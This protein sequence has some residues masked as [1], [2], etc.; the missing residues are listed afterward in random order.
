[1]SD[2]VPASDLPEAPE[3]SLVPATDLPQTAGMPSGTP[4]PYGMEQSDLNSAI[5]GR[6]YEPD[7]STGKE[8]ATALEGGIRGMTGGLSD[9]ALKGARTLAEKYSDDPDFWAPKTQDVAERADTTLG[10][11]ADYSGMGAGILA[12]AGMPGLIAKGAK[13]ATAGLGL[14]LK[15]AS[16]YNKLGATAL[17]MGL[18]SGLFQTSDEVSKAMLGQ[19]GG[20]PEAAVGSALG[21]IGAAGLLGLTLGGASGLPKAGLEAF[22]QSKTA[23][24]ASQ[25][26][27][28]FANRWH[29]N[30]AAGDLP[31]ALTKELEDFHTS[32]KDAADTVYGENGLKAQ[33]INK[34]VP[35]M[36]PGI[37]TQNQEIA[38]TM[39]KSLDKMT[40]NTKTF[41]EQYTENLQN[42]VNKWK[43][44]VT[45]PDSTSADRFNATQEMKQKLQ[46][47]A[48]YEKRITPFS[49]EAG[50]VNE[51]KNLAYDLRNKLEDPEVWGKA[52]EL[53]KGVNSAFSDFNPALKDFEKRFTSK[54]LGENVI[55]PG[56]VNTYA[57]QLGK[58][59]AEIKQDV[60]N[61]FVDAAEK[62]RK[63]IQGLHEKLGVENTVAPA[64][65]TALR[66]T[67]GKGLPNGA[68]AA[69]F[70]YQ[71]GLG[72]IT[73]PLMQ[74]MMGIKLGGT[75]GGPVGSAIGYVGA[76]AIGPTLE[77][78]VGRPLRRGAEASV[79]G[80]LK[81]LGSGETEGLNE[82]LDY[83]QKIDK[84]TKKIADK[85]NGLF[86]TGRQ[87]AISESISEKNRE[88]LRKYIGAGGINQDL[89][90]EQSSQESQPS[91]YALGGEITSPTV[92][93]EKPNPIENHFP[94]QSM[95]LNAAKARISN[96]LTSVKPQDNPMKKPFDPP[97]D[98]R[99]Q[100]RTYNSALDI[101]NHPL[102]ILDQVRDGTLRLPELK[103]FSS[104]YPEL[105]N[106]LNKRITERISNAQLDD[107]KPNYV[108][109]QAMSLFLGAPL[110]STMT[111]ASIMAAQTAFI[112]PQGPQQ[113]QGKSGGK[114]GTSTLGKSNDMYK[115]A[116]QAAESDTTSRD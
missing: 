113:P 104:M 116:T 65:L 66:G 64:P 29:Y 38:N 50:F 78:V 110:D 5:P 83:G 71:K 41:P 114:K 2:V 45:N 69:D 36:H 91:E 60:M 25:W 9:V 20:D 53:Q 57:N 96:Y 17:T 40:G 22:S 93:S 30:Q 37:Q 39:Q 6:E 27:S 68:K 74:R 107:E 112:R 95:L 51:V 81:A 101:A 82:V 4:V 11:V 85:V 103:H 7:A 54:E 86:K 35:E 62:Y 49:P 73:D 42:E 3:N 43:E 34:L 90:P 115:T 13:A 16:L 46:S 33:A 1:M 59:N 47:W 12:G 102:S 79:S 58:P 19:Q 92:Q 32:T 52:A 24:K 44:T 76:R 10:K 18:E 108:Q 72:Q 21:H 80:V 55:D 94:T 48:K 8:V 89:Q 87:T 63:E 84:G 67:L 15:G 88:K 99:G 70:M 100:E 106:Q 14:G 77:H 31:T 56:K 109:R 28:D 75:I 97:P 61:N 26:L 105:H 111:P 23:G 98:N